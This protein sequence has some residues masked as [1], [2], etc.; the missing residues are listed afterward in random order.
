MLGIG[1]LCRRGLHRLTVDTIQ[2]V[3]RT[4]WGRRP[5]VVC[6]VCAKNRGRQDYATKLRRGG[7][8]PRERCDRGH[9][10]AGENV[11]TLSRGER[12]CVPCDRIRKTAHRRRGRP[13]KVPR[14]KA[15]AFARRM[16]PFLRDDDLDDLAAEA[17]LHY[18]ATYIETGNDNPA[19]LHRDLVDAYRAFTGN[20]NKRPRPKIL[21]NAADA[22][23]D[24][25]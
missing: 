4:R 16:Y 1:D 25:P 2:V 24:R 21:T 22:V 6:R 15:V 7:R 20:R 23:F 14:D 12:V 10:L 9:E 8:P 5:H 18:F 11:R 19:S 3:E 13:P 17:W